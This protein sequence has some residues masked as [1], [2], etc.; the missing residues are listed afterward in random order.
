MS[1]EYLREALSPAASYAQLECGNKTSSGVLASAC[2]EI[3]NGLR[4]ML[5]VA[6]TLVSKL[7]ADHGIEQHRYV[8]HVACHWAIHCDPIECQS[9]RVGRYAADRWS[10]SDHATETSWSAKR[11]S[12]VGTGRQPGHARR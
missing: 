9:T 4:G 11:A 2:A 1:P 12:Q 10:E 8:T 3:S 7:T 6:P 5:G